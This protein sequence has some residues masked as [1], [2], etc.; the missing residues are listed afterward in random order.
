MADYQDH[1]NQA[2]KNLLILAEVNKSIPNSWDWQVTI[3]Y[4]VAVHLINGH[5]AK[6]ANLHYKTHVDV[7]NAIYSTIPACN[8]PQDVYLAFGKL[9]NY[10]RRAR[11]LCHDDMKSNDDTKAYLTYDRHLRKALQYLDTML[12]YFSSEYG[13]QFPNYS[14]D[15]IEIK[16]LTLK[17]FKYIKY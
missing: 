2:K 14:I 1:I 6:K 8:V 3:S 9:E 16:N 4:Y 13:E 7:K 15:C 12:S 17:Y 10:S 5:L 11:Y